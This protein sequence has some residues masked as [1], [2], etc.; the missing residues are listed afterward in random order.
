MENFIWP[1]SPLNER[2]QANV[3]GPSEPGAGEYGDGHQCGFAA[4]PTGGLAEEDHGEIEAPGDEGERDA[5]VANP[6]SARVDEGPRAARDDAQ[7]DE[8]ETE[9]HGVGDHVV[10]RGERRQALKELRDIFGQIEG[11]FSLELAFLD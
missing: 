2:A 1:C 5:R 8:D 10:E 7:R 3:R 11:L 4:P 9:A 6:G